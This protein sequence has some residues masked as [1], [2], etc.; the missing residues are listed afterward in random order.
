MGR[1][2]SSRARSTP[3]IGVCSAEMKEAVIPLVSLVLLLLPSPTPSQLVGN[4]G[5]ISD[6]PDNFAYRDEETM[7]A[8]RHVSEF[9]RQ[10]QPLADHEAQ[11]NRLVEVQ[12]SFTHG[13]A[14]ISF[15][16]WGSR[17]PVR[18]ISVFWHSDS[19][20]IKL[21]PENLARITKSNSPGE[22]PCTHSRSTCDVAEH[23]REAALRIKESDPSNQDG[24]TNRLEA[25]PRIGRA[26]KTETQ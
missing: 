4:R 10:Y 9:A 12:K 6:L 7:E 1:I 24:L 26:S 25:E 18:S 19:R 13:N 5:V 11:V 17:P 23:A 14:S 22:H 20:I 2:Q 21:L 3:S 15:F 8:S 16:T